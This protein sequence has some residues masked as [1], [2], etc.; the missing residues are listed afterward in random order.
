VTAPTNNRPE[1]DGDMR[2]RV[3][4]ASD[5]DANTGPSSG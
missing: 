5:A 4:D 1:V 3:S 2:D